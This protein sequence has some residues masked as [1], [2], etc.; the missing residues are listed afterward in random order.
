SDRPATG[1][2]SPI[3]VPNLRQTLLFLCRWTLI[4]LVGAALLLLGRALGTRAASGSA[5]PLE[6]TQ[7]LSGSAAGPLGAP[8][9]V[10][11][12]QSAGVEPARLEP[13]EAQPAMGR[14]SFA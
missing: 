12:S 5:A 8:V 4:G 6:A 14:R 3:P 9:P 11:S 7:A 1:T 10:S 2:T 13:A